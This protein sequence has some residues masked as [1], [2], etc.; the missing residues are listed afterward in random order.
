[1]WY[2][3]NEIMQNAIT[4]FIP[5]KIVSSHNVYFHLY[6]DDTQLYDH[7]C[8]S[9]TSVLIERLTACINDLAQSLAAHR[10]Q[11]N[12]SKT[13]LIWFGTHSSLS[14]IPSEHRW[15]SVG[16]SVVQSRDVVRNLG[17]S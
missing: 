7:C 10:L 17:V 15:L 9:D 14:K 13:E 11:L 5:Q 12:S 6:A 8:L 3:L 1:M 4:Q 16:S 2:A